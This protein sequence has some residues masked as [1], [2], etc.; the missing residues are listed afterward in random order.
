M[1]RG[2]KVPSKS[3]SE[4]RKSSSSTAAKDQ[5]SRLLAWAE[6]A[7]TARYVNAARAKL[8]DSLDIH[9]IGDLLYHAPHRYLDLSNTSKLGPVQLGDAT[10]V[11]TVY[12]VKKKMLRRA[13]RKQLAMT[14][15]TLVDDTGALIGVWFNQPWVEQ[16]YRKGQTLAFSGDVKY[17]SGLKQIVQPFVEKIADASEASTAEESDQSPHVSTVD[18]LAARTGADDEQLGHLGKILP[19]HGTTQGLSVGWLRRLIAA[20]I[21]DYGQ[22]GEY[23]PQS[24]LNGRKLTPY[25]WSLRNIHFP[26]TLAD[27][28]AART[29]LAYSELFDL[30][31][32]I[33]RRRYRAT[34]QTSGHAHQAFGSL[35]QALAESLSFALT[36]DQERAVSEI[37]D[38]MASGYPMQRLLLGDVGTGKTIVAAFALAVAADSGG[39]ATMMAPTEVLAQQYAEKLGPI[40]DN[41]GLKWGLLTGST[42]EAEREVLLTQLQSGEIK[43]L[44]GTHALLEPDVQFKQ[45]TLAI[46]DEQHRFGVQQ[47]KTLHE[48]GQSQHGEHDAN[49]DAQLTASDVL[50]MSATPIPRTLTLTAFGDLATSYLKTRPIAGAGITTQKIKFSNIGK[51]YDAIHSAVKSGRQA[52]IVCALVDESSK[53][54][55]QSALQMMEELAVGEFDNCTV[56]VLTGRMKSAQKAHIMDQF[57]AGDI[58][59]LI[60]TTVIE[61]GIDVHNATTMLVLDADR[62]GLAQLHQLRGR[63]GRGQHAGE[64]WLVSDSFAD[65]AKERFA[66]LL[67]TDD[68]FELAEL[69]LKQRGAGELLGTRQSGI[70]RLKVADL[71]SDEELVEAARQD[72]FELVATDPLLEAQELSMLRVRI[73]ALEAKYNEWKV[74]G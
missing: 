12:E 47:R 61:V 25:S 73:D 8:L 34:R 70:A 53:I 29:R 15:V 1:N 30:Q 41:I 20:A 36:E 43:V 40:F 3:S 11:G 67:Q 37:L 66:A 55:A 27:A 57:R 28:Q 46:V 7:L 13:G 71:G 26:S 64:V 49:S 68:G 39:Q 31:L 22:V 4:S 24:I 65:A 17:R 19:V 48:K 33:A 52:Y 50:V 42:T 16:T 74:A 2:S 59:V 35:H 69:D 56:E 38:D 5:A 63:V 10:V 21:D 44:F 14:E 18:A 23:L 72:A 6:P 45:M 58:D 54:E 62:Y 9:R 51:A 60:S 32:L